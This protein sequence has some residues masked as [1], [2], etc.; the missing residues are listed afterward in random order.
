MSFNFGLAVDE[1]SEGNEDYDNGDTRRDD[2]EE[3]NTIHQETTINNAVDRVDAD[4]KNENTHEEISGN[5][6]DS[7]RKAEVKIECGTEHG[8]DHDCSVAGNRIQCACHVGF[9]LDESDGKTCH[10]K[11]VDKYIFCFSV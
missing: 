11:F 4:K 7:L 3:I 10:G 5:D 2:D 1:Y 9:Y 6:P 8:C